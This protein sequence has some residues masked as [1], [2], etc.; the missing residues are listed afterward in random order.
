MLRCIEIC[1]DHANICEIG[2]REYAEGATQIINIDDSEGEICI[3][4]VYV[5]WNGRSHW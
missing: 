4:T 5:W 1:G 2:P 3:P